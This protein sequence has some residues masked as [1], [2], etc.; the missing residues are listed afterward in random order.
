MLRF[1]NRMTY[2]GNA[3]SADCITLPPRQLFSSAEE[4]YATLNHKA[5]QV[6]IGAGTAA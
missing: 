6:V 4:F 1:I 2:F 5:S 3:L